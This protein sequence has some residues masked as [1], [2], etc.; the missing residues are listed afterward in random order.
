MFAVK[1]TIQLNT[2]MT[3]LNHI[4]YPGGVIKGVEMMKKI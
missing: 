1:A 2:E 4:A 3:K